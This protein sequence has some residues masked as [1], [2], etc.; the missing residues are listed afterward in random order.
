VPQVSGLRCRP[1]RDAYIAPQLELRRDLRNDAYDYLGVNM[2]D[3]LSPD[4]LIR[5]GKCGKQFLAHKD[6]VI[7]QLYWVCTDCGKREDIRPDQVVA[8]Q[9][10]SEFQ[11]GE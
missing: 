9:G 11:S 8:I 1:E 7:L 10:A 2:H 6:Q 5:C 3:G 4:I